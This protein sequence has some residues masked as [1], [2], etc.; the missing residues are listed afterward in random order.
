MSHSSDPGINV[1]LDLMLSSLVQAKTGTGKTTAFLLPALQT[2][3]HQS[4][5]QSQ[6]S[7]LIMSPTRELAV[8][9]ATEAQGLV[10]KLKR[11]FE[12]HTAFGG[13]ARASALNRFKNGKPTVLVATPGRLIDYMSEP[14]FQQR[15][16]NLR[17]LILD[18]ADRMLDQGSR[19]P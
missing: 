7:V 2:T 18:E 6:V 1:P 14:G 3:L 10:S 17:T 4:V 19:S 15:F 16:K 8:Q 5:P 11:P 13:T 9:I 12:I